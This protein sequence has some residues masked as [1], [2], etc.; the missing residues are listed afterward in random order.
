MLL[1]AGVGCGSDATEEVIPPATPVPEPTSESASRSETPVPSLESGDATE[2]MAPEP[3]PQTVVSRG[4]TAPERSPQ[5]Y[6]GTRES[7][8]PAS[9]VVESDPTCCLL[10]P[11]SPTATSTGP[12]VP[13][14]GS[15][16]AYVEGVGEKQE[17]MPSGD[18]VDLNADPLDD[19]VAY[20]SFPPTSGDHWSTPVRCG[21][22]I[23]P[24]PDELVV[25]NMEHSNIV[26]SYNLTSQD[27]IDALADVYQDLPELWRE[28]FTV[29]R[30][31]G[32]IGDGEVALSTWGVLDK[33]TD[34]VDRE[35]ILRF[36]EHYVGRLGPEGAISCR[37]SQ[38]SMPGG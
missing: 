37:G 23:Q 36:F 8:P 6:E 34:G 12:G 20:D 15:A 30:P 32:K 19:I 9:P 11:P 7:V 2:T 1:V 27:D 10:P 22:Y 13:P 35:R 26:V 24:V 28:H 31:Y 33:I 29:V 4:T 16:V 3:S 21:F 14:L 18:H 17:I 25:H 38:G 5:H